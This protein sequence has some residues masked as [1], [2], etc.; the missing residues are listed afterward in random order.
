MSRMSQS[1][2]PS[3]WRSGASQKFTRL[4]RQIISKPGYNIS[5]ARVETGRFQALWVNWILTC[6]RPHPGA[7]AAR[8]LIVWRRRGRR[9]APASWTGTRRRARS[10]AGRCPR[11]R[12]RT[13]RMCTRSRPKCP[14][15]SRRHRRR[16]RRRRYRRHRRYLRRRRYLRLPF[17]LLRRRHPQLFRLLLLLLLLLLLRLP[18]HP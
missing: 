13:C 1:G 4:K 17:L 8:R 6:M 2:G 3:P 7:C 18:R 14:R 15:P 5:G 11:C 12:R 16:R 10:G 9:R